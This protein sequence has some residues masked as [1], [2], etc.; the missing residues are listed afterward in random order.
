LQPWQ[1]LNS[2]LL[3]DRSPWLRVLAED[4]QLPDG[5][6]VEAYLRLDTPDY[7]MVV[8]VDDQR[9]IGFV[10]SYKRG[11]D[12]IDLQPPAGM[13]EPGEDPLACAQRELLEEMGCQAPT[14]HAMGR[15]VI[16]GNMRGG[17]AHLFLATGC[18]QVAEPDSGDLEEQEVVWLG[19]AD[20]RSLWSGGELAQ[21][22]S[23]AALGL[24]FAHLDLS[25]LR[26]E[27]R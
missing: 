19:E 12:G 2:R 22:S 9:R 20:A 25:G 5:R 24:A 14:W 8:P 21:M 15:Y 17:W 16:G 3:L 6:V 23:A 13:I 10:R 27:G 26:P 11:V 1:T 18:H 7:I 4:V